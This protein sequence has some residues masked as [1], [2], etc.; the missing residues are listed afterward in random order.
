[1]PRAASRERSLTLIAS[2]KASSASPCP[3]C[4][5]RCPPGSS[6][7]WAAS[8]TTTYRLVGEIGAGGAWAAPSCKTAVH[9]ARAQAQRHTRD[10]RRQAAKKGRISSLD[11]KTLTSEA[12]A[13]F[14]SAAFTVRVTTPACLSLLATRMSLYCSAHLVQR[15][16]GHAAEKLGEE[17]RGFLR[18]HVARKGHFAQLLHGNGIGEERDVCF[19]A[20]DHGHRLAGVA[21]V[22]DIG[23]LANL[24]RI[25]AQQLVQHDRMQ[26]AQV[27]LPLALWQIG[28]C[29]VD[30]IRLRAEQEVPTSCDGDEGRALLLAQIIHVA[31]CVCHRQCLYR[32][33]LLGGLG[34]RLR[35][36]TR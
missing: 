19:A 23:L 1:M 34:K 31:H 17:V 32:E 2:V 25:Q 15:I 22:A 6:P 16:D 36:K 29:G 10:S 24:F 7:P 27:E 12:Q 35:V 28:Q 8:S 21:Q 5:F 26:V 11:D 14:D 20:P 13:P 33:K 18:H 30:H 3:V 4:P 9:A